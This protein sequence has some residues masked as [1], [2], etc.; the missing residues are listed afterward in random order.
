MSLSEKN[1]EC[2]PWTIEI[3]KGRRRR[4]CPHGY[5]L[6]A[7]GCQPTLANVLPYT[8]VKPTSIRS[9]SKSKDVKIA[10]LL[11]D[12]RRETLKKGYTIPMTRA[13][14]TFVENAI[15][16][17]L[18]DVSAN[19]PLMSTL[20]KHANEEDEKLATAKG[21]GSWF[22]RGISILANGTVRV[23][24]K[25]V[26]LM[27]WLWGRS[28]YVFVVSL[29]LLFIKRQVC[30]YWQS[31]RPK[32]LVEVDPPDTTSI[33]SAAIDT[34]A[35]LLGAISAFGG[36]LFG[37][38]S[39]FHAFTSVVS[40][41][42][43]SALTGFLG[44]VVN[45]ILS[46][47]TKLLVN[48]IFEWL[49]L[50]MSKLPLQKLGASSGTIVLFVT[51]LQEDCIKH[52]QMEQVPQGTPGAI[53]SSAALDLEKHF[54]RYKADAQLNSKKIHTA[55]ENT[56]QEMS[57]IAKRLRGDIKNSDL[58][59][60]A[61]THPG[62]NPF[63][64]NFQTVIGKPKAELKT[65]N[66]QKLY[67][68]EKLYPV[69]N[70]RAEP[71]AKILDPSNFVEPKTFEKGFDELNNT[72]NETLKGIIDR[73]DSIPTEQRTTHEVEARRNA[74]YTLSGREQTI[75][76]RELWNDARMWGPSV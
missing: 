42:L 66:P 7:C 22:R 32:F 3:R 25:V 10:D 17:I 16:A 76:W 75:P 48:K 33:T 21:W 8:K 72:S 59:G 73:I 14:E 4:K 71:V 49:G 31:K 44:P 57:F 9:G 26:D 67:E 61:K 54:E 20:V 58:P 68:L 2:I 24:G 36:T 45:T 43:A 65:Y 19:A 52:I 40:V 15:P 18:K 6:H 41:G 34:G 53:T 12:E 23:F 60:Y 74:I 28:E 5:A 29:I 47:L 35:S 64:N 39:N 69:R 50:L 13:E 55:A 38:T 46:Q 30:A 27:K 70:D 1:D 51:M 63:L 56:E 37:L 62:K 11:N